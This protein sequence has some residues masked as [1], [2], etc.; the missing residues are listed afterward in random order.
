MLFYSLSFEPCIHEKNS[1][2]QVKIKVEAKDLF[3]QCYALNS[4]LINANKH[5]SKNDTTTN[6]LCKNDD[7]RC[8]YF[9]NIQ[10]ILQCY[11]STFQALSWLHSV[12]NQ[13]VFLQQCYD[14]IQILIN[15]N[16]YCFNKITTN[17]RGNVVDQQYIYFLNTGLISW[18]YWSTLAALSRIWSIMNQYFSSPCCQLSDKKDRVNGWKCLHVFYNWSSLV[19]PPPPKFKNPIKEL[20]ARSFIT[21]K[22]EGWKWV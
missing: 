14:W 9:L 11:W 8:L 15:A 3:Q 16:H 20:T 21:H 2:P 17:Y 18:D 7:Q 5:D 10:L 12:T 4:N 6:N 19:Q 13:Y 1:S 22:G